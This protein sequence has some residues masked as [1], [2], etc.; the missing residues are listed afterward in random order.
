MSTVPTAINGAGRIGLLALRSLIQR[1]EC[2]SQKTKVVPV[3]LNDP[4]ADHKNLLYRLKND[5]VHGKFQYSAELNENDHTLTIAGK[6]TMHLTKVREPSE[7]PYKKHNVKMV[8]ECSGAFTQYEKASQH[9]D[10]G[11]TGVQTV[12]ISAPGAGEGIKT[13]VMG[14]NHTEYDPKKH[15]VISNASCTTNCLAPIVKVLHDKY[16]ISWGAMTTCHATTAT[17][18]TVD[19]VSAKDYA[20]GRCAMANIIPASTGAAKAIGLVFPDLMGKLN[21]NALRVPLPD[22]SVT[23]FVCGVGK[24]VT[25][26]QINAD[27]V[28]ASKGNLKGILGI[29]EQYAVSS[30]IIGDSHSSVVIPSSVMVFNNNVVKV[31]SFYDNEWGY[32]CRLIDLACYVAEKSA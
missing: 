23:D 27:F 19:G 6:Y 16:K 22:V 26:E 11:K 24:D 29:A 1:L 12:V 25:V 14:V 15:Q 3:L 2:G 8:L 17:Q 10:N 7:V 31:H 32:S 4:F 21:G 20:S 28:E 9:I 5:T 13:L 18:K 30:D